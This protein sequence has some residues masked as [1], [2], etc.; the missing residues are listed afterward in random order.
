MTIRK[1]N[2]IINTSICLKKIQRAKE[3]VNKAKRCKTGNSVTHSHWIL[4]INI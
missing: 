2:V 4:K 1:L 3:H